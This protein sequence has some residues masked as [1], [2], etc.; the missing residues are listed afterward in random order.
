MDGMYGLGLALP[1]ERFG[2]LHETLTGVD[3]VTGNLASSD[4]PSATGAIVDFSGAIAD[5]DA[6][7]KGFLVALREMAS[8]ADLF[9]SV[10]SDVPKI[11]EHSFT[12]AGGASGAIK[13]VGSDIGK[14]LGQGVQETLWTQMGTSEDGGNA[15]THVLGDKIGGA[16][17]T[18]L[19]GIG[20]VIGPLAGKLFGMIMGIGGP[21]QQEL[22][23][24]K[25]EG[26]FEKIVRCFQ[27]MMDA[28]GAAYA[29]TGRGAQQA[30][31][32]VKALMDAEKNGGAGVQTM[33]DKINVAFADQKT[34]AADVQ[35]GVDGILTAAKT[36]GG[37]FP[38]AMK[39]LVAQLVA[40][41]GLT[42]AEKNSLLGLTG[43]VEPD[44]QKLTATAK[45][46]GLGLTD[47]GPA[48]EQADISG[49]ADK[50]LTDFKA[51]DK[52]GADS[53]AV[54]HGMGKSIN[55]LIN[56]AR[57]Y[58]SSLPTALKPLAEQL[59]KTGPLT[60]DA[61]HKLDDLSGVKF[62]DAGD[63]L[64]KGMST[65]TDALNRLGDLLDP[66]SPKGLAAKA[67]ATAADIGAALGGIPDRHIKILYD[68][69]G[70]GDPSYASRGGFVTSRGV[71]YFGDGGFVPRGTDTVR[72][73]LTPGEAVLTREATLMLGP[74][75]I[76]SLNAGRTAGSG[77]ALPSGLAGGGVYV[78]V[79]VAGNVSTERDLASAIQT[80]LMD[81]VRRTVQLNLRGQ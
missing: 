75:L 1:V 66:N 33:I 44:F 15:L 25:I 70:D 38:D 5:F 13:A 47:L 36:V 55:T 29:A 32:D 40:L 8:G 74:D 72:A 68:R 39:P 37:D 46:Y 4:L 61:G 9:D 62:D 10:M 41:P 59:A 18:A 12:G 35:T 31:V 11:L 64:A 20:A 69:S 45:T 28:V 27:G 73:M 71:E 26:S 6:K 80:Y 49:R 3:D 48:F 76:R 79:N 2:S 58:G 22:D 56:D 78:T 77:R 21:S 14:H 51:L 16:L 42:D 60:D 19:P 67:T 23:G 34:K 53:D 50:I 54:L 57:K 30:Q 17:T 43:A 63:P 24:R 7:G 52:A 65:L 81:D